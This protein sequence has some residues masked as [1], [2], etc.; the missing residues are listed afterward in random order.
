MRAFDRLNCQFCAYANGKAK[1]WNDEMD[2]IAA[3]N[4]RKGNPFT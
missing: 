2:E 1:L 4:F 3:V